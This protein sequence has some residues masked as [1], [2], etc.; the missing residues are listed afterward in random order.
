MNIW[1]TVTPNSKSFSVR[2]EGVGIRIRAT[3]EPEKGR[4]NAEII[5]ELGRIT[6]CRVIII[7]GHKSRRKLLGVDGNEEEILERIRNEG[8]G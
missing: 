3:E 2:I 5:R 6:E 4:V 7:R 8:R 1:A